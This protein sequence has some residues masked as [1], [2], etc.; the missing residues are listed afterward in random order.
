MQTQQLLGAVHGNRDA[1][2]AFVSITAGTVSPLEF[3]DSDHIGQIFASAQQ[4]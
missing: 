3:F 2:D 1:M 4:S